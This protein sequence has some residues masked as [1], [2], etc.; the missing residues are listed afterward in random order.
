VLPQ[1][2]DEHHV[3]S[4]LVYTFILFVE[5]W[6]FF[7][8][9]IFILFGV[10][11]FDKH[12]LSLSWLFHVFLFCLVILHLGWSKYWSIV[13]GEIWL[14]LFFSYQADES[15]WDFHALSSTWIR[16]II[17]RKW[18]KPWDEWMNYHTN[19]YTCNSKVILQYY[20]IYIFI[21]I[22]YI[23]IYLY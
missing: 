7:Y 9:F 18:T 17:T 2:W 22:N 23:Y 21:C 12:L 4:G 11:R 10:P 5:K 19:I 13:A 6:S 14:F 16:W 20:Y 8:F 3:Q 15:P 1:L